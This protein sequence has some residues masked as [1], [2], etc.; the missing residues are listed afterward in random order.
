MKKTKTKRK[1]TGSPYVRSRIELAAI[2]GCAP[3]SIT[4]WMHKHADDPTVDSL[5]SGNG[6]WHVENWRA[7]IAKH[8]LNVAEDTEPDDVDSLSSVRL[9]QERLKLA[10]L[11]RR[12]ALEAGK[13]MEVAK[14]AQILEEMCERVKMTMRQIF[15]DELPPVVAGLSAGAVRAE[16][17][18]ANDRFLII[19]R[20]YANKLPGLP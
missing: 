20:E 16:M 6:H 18:K 9:A 4:R 11:Q 13:L 7:F 2:L 12:E 14:A 10:T 8:G 1:K 17:R 5:R 19:M 15:E 3:R